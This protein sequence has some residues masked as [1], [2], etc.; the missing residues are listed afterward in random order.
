MLHSLLSMPQKMTK[1]YAN[2]TT[3]LSSPLGHLKPLAS[4][5]R[6]QYMSCDMSRIR[7]SA[8]FDKSGY[9]EDDHLYWVFGCLKEEHPFVPGR[10]G[11]VC[12][13]RYR[14]KRIPSGVPVWSRPPRANTKRVMR[15][16]QH[17]VNDIPSRRPALNKDWP[18]NPKNT[19]F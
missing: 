7:M 19:T 6:R 11:M 15:S 14:T 1:I 17:Q 16:H 8:G 9:Y 3:N 4:L 10:D 18:V 2:R 12:D 13:R 5:E